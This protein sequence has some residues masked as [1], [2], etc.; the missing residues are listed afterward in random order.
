MA[1]P[2]AHARAGRVLP[3]ILAAIAVVVVLREPPLLGSSD[4]AWHLYEAKRVLEGQT[5]YTDIF[6]IIPPGYQ[7]LMALCFRLFG[8]TIETAKTVTA[9][10]H[11]LIVALVF[12]ICRRLGVRTALAVPL[13]LAHLAIFQPAWPHASPHWLSTLLALAILLT[14]LDRRWTDRASRAALPGVLTGLLLAVQHQ[15][16]LVTAAGVLFLLAAEPF[17]TRD[18]R[19]TRARLA[20]CVAGMLAVVLPVV[21]VVIAGAGG[22]PV[23]RALVLQP[24]FHYGSVNRYRWGQVVVFTA[25]LA[26]HTFP[27]LLAWLPAVLVST[28][29]RTARAALRSEDPERLRRLVVLD[30]FGVVSIA[31]ITYLPDFV[32]IALVAPVFAI[33]TGE[34]A[35]AALRTLPVRAAAWAS[36]LVGVAG[37]AAVAVQVE[38]NAAR[39]RTEYALRHTTPFGVV[40]FRSSEEIALVEAIMAAM[41]DVPQRTLFVYPGYPALYLLTATHNPT[42][43]QLLLPRYNFPDQLEAAIATLERIPV[44]YVVLVA[45]LI[46]RDDPIFAYVRA[47]YEDVDVPGAEAATGAKLLRRKA[48]RPG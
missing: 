3:V 15:R 20:W 29:L 5:F 35:E 48:I 17:V 22:W 41:R 11:G 43:H 19:S 34:A 24:L 30:V 16:G 9:V 33:L 37:V 1:A 21:A 7:W 45:K 12:V 2:P 27:R 40:A 28:V 44:P 26:G 14:L 23:L 47:H 42:P 18:R 6:D 46:G 4:E 31:S 32:H 36:I 8:T 13:A 25:S 38:R 39:G 10:M